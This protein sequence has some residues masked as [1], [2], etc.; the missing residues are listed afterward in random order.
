M[1]DRKLSKDGKEEVSSD[2]EEDADIED[3]ARPLY[4]EMDD[5][6]VRNYRSNSKSMEAFGVEQICS[7]LERDGFTLRR[8]SH[9]DDA[10]SKNVIQY[11]FPC[12]PFPSLPPFF[13]FDLLIFSSLYFPLSFL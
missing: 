8:F 9:D 7:H 4:D 5:L 10:S 3:N 11:R 2:D 6:V 13:F 12:A 1:R